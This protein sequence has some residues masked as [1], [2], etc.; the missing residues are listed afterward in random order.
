MLALNLF[1]GL[2]E[3][4]VLIFGAYYFM[5]HNGRTVYRPK[6]YYVLAF[7]GFIAA[8]I[9]SGVFLR[10]DRASI[11]I[12]VALTVLIGHFL[13]HPGW[14]YAIYDVFYMVCI[15]LCQSAV[16]WAV[17]GILGTKSLME[18][19]LLFGNVCLMLKVISELGITIFL[20]YLTG[21]KKMSRLTR[22]QSVSMFILPVASIVLMFSMY[23][24]GSVYLQLYGISLLAFN[25]ALL[26]LVNLY[27][28]YLLGYMFQANNLEHEL[29]MFQKQNEMQFRYYDDLEKKY[30]QSRKIIHDMKNHLQAV[31]QL[32]QQ[33]ESERA[34][35]YV[36]NL[37]HMLNVLGEK[38]YSDHKMLNIILNDKL[39]KAEREG[40]QVKASIGETMLGKMK[41]ID[42]TTVFANLLDNAIEAAKESGKQGFLH[43]KMD[44]IHDFNVISIVNAKA[45]EKKKDGHMGLGLENVRNTLAQYHGTMQ[46]E[47]TETEYRVNIMIPE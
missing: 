25:F 35:E 41:D 28:L 47:A 44:A 32:Y 27:F 24:L 2:L 39:G 17:S 38:Y 37:Y 45:G 5:A 15:F 9:G 3:V 1:L 23:I 18:D 7:G 4:A 22:W 40:I 11:V 43:I 13:F 6:I 8:L 46:T 10:D 29:D 12:G 34:K 19:P 33:Q 36:E 26:L 16:I 21:K 20:T 14:K 31:E 30:G 42:V